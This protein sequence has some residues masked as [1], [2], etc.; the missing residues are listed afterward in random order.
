MAFFSTTYLGL[1]AEYRCETS[2]KSCSRIFG[3]GKPW[4]A[5]APARWLNDWRMTQIFAPEN[6]VWIEEDLLLL[7]PFIAVAD[8]LGADRVADRTV[9]DLD[10]LGRARAVP[11]DDPLLQDVALFGGGA[12][13]RDELGQPPCCH[14]G[15]DSRVCRHFWGRR[16]SRRTEVSR[17]PVENARVQVS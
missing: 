1:K 10:E 4:Q 3:G 15:A 12:V 6:T 7:E 13:T 2:L 14:D 8:P 17:Q 16:T 9:T 5:V 11:F